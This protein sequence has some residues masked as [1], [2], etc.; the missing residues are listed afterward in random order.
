MSASIPLV[1]G[2]QAASGTKVL[3]S[4]GA[5]TEPTGR[6]P[7]LISQMALQ[8]QVTASAVPTSLNL[9]VQHS[10]DGG[11]TWDDFISFLQVGAVGTARQIAQWNRDAVSASAVHAAS[12]AALTAGTVINGPVGDD[13]RLKW[14]IV[15]TSY[16]F[17]VVARQI[18]RVR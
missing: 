17:S 14:V 18:Q 10:L 2:L 3:G 1:S 5:V 12:D 13:W 15:G 4:T 6:L 7:H 11:T 8:F 16:T 9:Y